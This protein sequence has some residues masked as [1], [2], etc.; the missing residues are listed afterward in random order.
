MLVGSP[1][2]GHVIA[3]RAGHSL[4]VGLVETIKKATEA[5]RMVTWEDVVYDIASRPPYL[6]PARI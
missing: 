4:H 2:L 1:L 6:V 3:Y 5:W